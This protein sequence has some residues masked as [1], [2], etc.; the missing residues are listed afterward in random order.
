MMR[1]LTIAAAA[2][3]GAAAAPAPAHA[4]GYFIAEYRYVQVGWPTSPWHEPPY[5]AAP[6]Y[7]HPAPP[8]YAYYPY[9]SSR[10]HVAY[11]VHKKHWQEPPLRVRY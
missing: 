3:L 10:R 5:Y 4:G 6:L 1:P 7:N 11:T 2:M 9:G 8:Y